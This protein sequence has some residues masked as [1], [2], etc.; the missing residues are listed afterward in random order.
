MIVD[1][2]NNWMKF[3]EVLNI[4]IKFYLFKKKVKKESKLDVFF[5]VVLIYVM[6]DNFNCIIIIFI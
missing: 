3:V 4:L 6:L 5:D 2:Y 1:I